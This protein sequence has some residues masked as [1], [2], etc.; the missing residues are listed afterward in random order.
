MLDAS[1][2]DRIICRTAFEEPKLIIRFIEKLISLYEILLQRS[3][4]PQS[5]AFEMEGEKERRGEE[6]EKDDYI[7]LLFERRIS[8]EDSSSV[9][10]CRDN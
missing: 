10:H 7:T 3:M 6:K 4:C 9:K 5:D 8:T 1:K 2:S